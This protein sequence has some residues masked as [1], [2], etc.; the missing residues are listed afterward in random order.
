MS[1]HLIG[2]YLLDY[3]LSQSHNSGIIYLDTQLQ[4]PID[5][6]QS[7]QPHQQLAVNMA[8]SSDQATPLDIASPSDIKTVAAHTETHDAEIH[9]RENTLDFD[10]SP[11]V[12][13]VSASKMEKPNDTQDE[14]AIEDLKGVKTA[15]LGSPFPS[16]KLVA[17]DSKSIASLED[18]EIVEQDLDKDVGAILVTVQEQREQR[19]DKEKTELGMPHYHHQGHLLM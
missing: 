13:E 6:Y 4:Q 5:Y 7:E 14:V 3:S 16:P 15:T 17:E 10:P 19:D 12:S 9:N 11:I 1:I 18:G 2:L 8:T